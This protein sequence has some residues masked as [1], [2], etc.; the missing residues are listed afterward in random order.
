MLVE[1]LIR[2]TLDLQGV[3]IQS[4]VKA[5]SELIV[6]LRPDCR[7]HPRCGVCG[8]PGDY[9]DTLSERRFRHV[10]LWG[11]PVTLIYAPCRV[12]CPRCKSVHV[13]RMSWAA[14]KKRLTRA[15]AVEIA[16][17]AK[18]LPWQQVARQFQC[19][20]GTVAAAVA[21]VVDFG[22]ARRDLSCITHI[23]IDEISRQ[24]GHVYLTN[25]YDLRT[26]TL[27]WSGEG[28]TKDTLNAFFEFFGPE[29]TA[30]LV[31]ICSDMWPS[32]FETIKAKA[33]QA[34]LV[35]DKFHIVR[36]LT[37]AVD[38]VR[39][40]EV[41][42][43]SSEHKEVLAGTRYIWLK[44][45]WNL[46]DKQKAS[47]SFLE[48][49]NL[50]INRAYL[51]KES[52]RDFWQSATKEVATRFMNQWS[53][54]AMESKIKPMQDFALLLKRHED[55]IL[56]YF[57]MPISNGAV[58]GLNNKAKVISHRAYGFRSAK[59]YILN[60]YHCMGNLPMPTNLHRFV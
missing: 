11:I 12:T 28:R 56:T 54:W 25:V 40:Q 60:L 14:G 18:S 13:E 48:T 2:E 30:K 19:S 41:N 27:I 37:E 59:T 35:F 43:K 49:L 23:G 55:N 47:L 39:R 9:R 5:G 15:F 3:R 46:T 21:Y 29:R 6:T 53:T 17:W 10:P 52:F 8:S 24:K 45:P 16:T 42:D 4:T 58:E 1:Q 36:K 7:C 34:T 57:D 32:Y 50:N 38:S 20:W 44:N 26:G 31:G 33:P 51:L 22:L